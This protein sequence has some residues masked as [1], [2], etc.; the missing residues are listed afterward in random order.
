MNVEQLIESISFLPTHMSHGHKVV[1][2]DS[3]IRLIRVYQYSLA[4][5]LAPTITDEPILPKLK[6]PNEN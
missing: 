5:S 3:V 1:K 4:G 2:R 6:E